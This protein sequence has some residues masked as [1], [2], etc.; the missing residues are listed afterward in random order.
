MSYKLFIF[1]LDGTIGNTIPLCIEA[2]QKAIEPLLGQKVSEQEI[3][4]TFG[5]S[6]EGT[7]ATLIPDHYEEGINNYLKHYEELHND[8]PNPFSEIIKILDYLRSKN[9][10]IAMVTG[11]GK[12]STDITLKRYGI[13]E[14]F[15]EIETG[16]PLGPRKPEALEIVFSK[17]KNILREEVVY[18]GDADSDITA[19]KLVNIDIISAAWSK[20]TD[21]DYLKSLNP[22]YI[23]TSTSD[24]YNW[25]KTLDLK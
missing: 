25:L 7:I 4:S 10:D 23:F 21:I 18:I 20:T 6:E 24:F 5:P 19:C 3:I 16:S 2:F 12:K 17:Y 11:K 15:Q 13:T 8:S 14:Y 22:N 1:D 9:I